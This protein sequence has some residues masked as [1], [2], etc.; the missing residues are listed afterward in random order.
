MDN[1]DNRGKCCMK[2][3]QDYGIL[4]GVGGSYGRGIYFRTV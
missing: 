4:E 3:K 2:L 1:E